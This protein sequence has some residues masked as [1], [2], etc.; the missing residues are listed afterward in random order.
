VKKEL[1]LSIGKSWKADFPFLELI[2][3]EKLMG[4]HL[5]QILRQTIFDGE[6]LLIE[7]EYEWH[8]YLSL[9]VS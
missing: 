1:Q 7:N 3:Y 2:C 8:K 5:G 9:H 4:R 6:S